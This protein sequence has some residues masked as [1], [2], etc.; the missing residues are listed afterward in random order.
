MNH[1]LQ[2]LLVLSILNFGA[3]LR[4]KEAWTRL[5]TVDPDSIFH[6]EA[7]VHE[8]QRLYFN[9]ENKYVKHPIVFQY[10]ENCG[11]SCHEK[12]SSKLNAYH[13]HSPNQLGANII[14]PSVT[15]ESPKHFYSIIDATHAL[16]HV[17]H[18]VAKALASEFPDE[19]ID[20]APV[21]PSFKVH[22]NVDVATICP[23]GA[24][25]ADTEIELYVVFFPQTEDALSTL[26]NDV[27]A[28]SLRT[29]GNRVH[30]PFRYVEKDLH[31]L[32]VH[33]SA[34]LTIKTY[35]PDLDE[36]VRRFSTRPDVQW[37]EV[38]HAMK[39]LIRWA[40]NVTQTGLYNEGP[41][42]HIGITGNGRIIGIA[43]TGLDDESCY[44]KDPSS[45][46]PFDF[47]NLSHRKVVYYNTYVDDEDGDG[48]G[49]A[50][51]GTA[52]GRCADGYGFDDEDGAISNSDEAKE[53]NGQAWDA[54]IAFFD[55]G[56]GGGST[57]S[58]L[59]VPGDAK[60]NLYKPLYNTGARV[61]SMS[62]GSASNSYTNDA[63]YVD[64]FMWN[65][66]D[67]LILHAAGNSGESGSFTSVSNSVGSPAT[68]KN[69]VSVGATSNDEKAWN[70]QGVVN[71]DGTQ[72][73]KNS[74]A[75]FSSRGPTSD[76]RAKPDVCAVGWDVQA[77]LHDVS[78][79]AEDHCAVDPISGTSFSCP[80]LAGTAVLIEEYFVDGWYGNGMKNGSAGFSP[81]GALLK[82]ML[83]HG[84]QPLHQVQMSN[85]N[86]EST[87]WLDDYQGFGRAQVDKGTNFNTNATRDGLTQF[88]L[89]ASDPASEH[90]VSMSSCTTHTY[91]FTV[92]NTADLPDG[93]DSPSTIY[94][95]LAWTDYPGTVGSSNILVNDFDIRIYDST[96]TNH[97]A[98]RVSDRKNNVEMVKI[99]NPEA[100]REYTVEIK[101]ISLSVAQPYALVLTGENGKV[102]VP[103]EDELDLGLS[104][105]AITAISVM[106]GI[107]CCLTICVYWIAYGSSK[108][109]AMLKQANT[110]YAVQ[111]AEQKE[112]NAE[113]KKARMERQR[114]KNQ[115]VAMTK[116]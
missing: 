31:S 16:V 40:K 69:G 80:L 98:V 18:S 10:V 17:D 7:D 42:H 19:I 102:D 59:S 4:T 81:S 30:S 46:F 84:A 39:S 1:F 99:E 58:S 86:T 54:K 115:G 22:E 70:F 103:P 3:A 68:N 2:S 43:D 61:L 89:G 60:N 45:V 76:G 116:V 104:Q 67:S 90:Y 5:F 108:R 48:H 107:T 49:T 106:S 111:L 23:E 32:A 109:K 112:K 47:V 27:K 64:D 65:Y 53:Y 105:L 6:P 88:V 91:D 93:Q 87:E 11:I 15:T 74:L 8:S 20:F 36:T 66:P 51:A 21:L 83:I 52:A 44:F 95:T 38:K 63:R 26:Q 75:G 13:L 114:R 72:Y 29:E 12:L 96:G 14:H 41:L 57:T 92:V 37:V 101:C 24:D 77:P 56:S 85:G 35:C 73:N 94:A 97:D 113:R 62:W 55:I 33:D 78:L 34:T 50:V 110:Q 82:A 71:G 9:D 25:G 79:T 28:S 100:G